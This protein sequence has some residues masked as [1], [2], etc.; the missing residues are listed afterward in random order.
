LVFVLHCFFPA[1]IDAIRDG[2]AV[3]EPFVEDAE[4]PR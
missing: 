2:R 3:R 1:L 4:Q